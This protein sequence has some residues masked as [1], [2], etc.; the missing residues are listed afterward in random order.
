M[1]CAVPLTL[2]KKEI[3][4]ISATKR[5]KVRIWPYNIPVRCYQKKSPPVSRWAVLFGGGRSR[6]GGRSF[7]QPPGDRARSEKLQMLMGNSLPYIP[8]IPCNTSQGRAENRP[9]LRGAETC[10]RPLVD[11]SR[12][13]YK[14]WETR[15]A[16]VSIWL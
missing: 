9:L 14:S 4:S 16:G 10:S 7:T 15:R 12:V 6:T 13:L 5:A 2:S 8:G 1:R 3:P 11:G